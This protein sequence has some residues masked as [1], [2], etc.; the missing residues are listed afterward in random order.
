[1]LV[2]RMTFRVDW[3]R[4]SFVRVRSV[5]PALTALVPHRLWRTS[6][7]I[8][9]HLDIVVIAKGISRP[10]GIAAL[11]SFRGLGLCGVVLS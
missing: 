7:T 11:F 2:E 3:R 4:E 1:V 9:L 5:D 8:A 10:L 6:L